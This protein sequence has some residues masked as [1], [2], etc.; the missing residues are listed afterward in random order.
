MRI[1]LFASGHVGRAALATML[2]TGRPPVALVAEEPE[3]GELRAASELPA[4]AAFSASEVETDWGRTRLR[5]LDPDLGILAWWNRLIRKP[6]LEVPRLGFLN[7]HPSFLPHD[8]GKHY[9]FWTL[10]EETPFGVTIHWITEG[11]DDG[12]IAFQRPIAKSWTDTGETLYARCQEEMVVLFRD[13]LD[14]IWAGEIPRI[15]QPEGGSFHRADELER[16]SRIDLD[17]TYTA[18]SLLNVLRGR[19]FPPH[20]GAWFEDDGE[21]YEIELRIRRVSGD[22]Q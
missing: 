6:L 17:R 11:V 10:A 13:N 12:D 19:T 15:P 5:S 1:A 18:R 4:D 2:E 21:R 8:R 7:F 3:L 9:N 22:E 14:R 16:A 20:P